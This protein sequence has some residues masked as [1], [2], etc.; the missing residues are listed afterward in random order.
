MSFPAN[1]R[2]AYGNCDSYFVESADAGVYPSRQALREMKKI[3][4]EEIANELSR[5]A[6]EEHVED[7]VQHMSRMEVSMVRQ[8]C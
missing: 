7:V 8:K 2:P 5:L 3:R 1:P 6:Y 4:Q